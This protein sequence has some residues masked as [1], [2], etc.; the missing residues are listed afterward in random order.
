[1]TISI[2][3]VISSCRRDISPDQEFRKSTFVPAHGGIHM[4]H[5][6]L[7]LRQE[8]TVQQFLQCG[9]EV[10]FDQLS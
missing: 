5:A 9:E 6:S 4:L 3:S 10:P 1:M 7:V 8:G 2:S